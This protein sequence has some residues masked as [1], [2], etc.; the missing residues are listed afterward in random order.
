MYNVYAFQ[1]FF[2]FQK[3]WDIKDVLKH[4][5]GQR[6]HQLY[7]GLIERERSVKEQPQE[8]SWLL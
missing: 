7:Q 8:A 2:W 4:T 3:Y 1:C 5:V 6:K